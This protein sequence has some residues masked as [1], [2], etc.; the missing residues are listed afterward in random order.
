MKSPREVIF[1]QGDKA[2]RKR[3]VNLPS[4]FLELLR[5]PDGRQRIHKSVEVI[6]RKLWL[7]VEEEGL[8][9]GRSAL[10]VLAH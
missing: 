8:A 6:V 4:V 7:F 10:I 5:S 3:Y 2:T 9:L 1:L